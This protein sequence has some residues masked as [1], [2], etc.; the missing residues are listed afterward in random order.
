MAIC[1]KCSAGPSGIEGHDGLFA[2]FMSAGQFDF[3]CEACGTSWVRRY[4]GQGGFLWAL[5]GSQEPH[6][7]LEV[8]G[9]HNAERR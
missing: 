8:P 6:R 4:E 5:L 9:S 1:A 2:M 3:K 7:G